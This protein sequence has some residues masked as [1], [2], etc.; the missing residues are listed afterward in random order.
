MTVNRESDLDIVVLGKHDEE[1]IKKI[2]QRQII[3]IN[4]H[5]VSYNEF[6]KMLNS[7]NP[8][9]LEIIKNHVLFGDISRIVDIFWRR[10][11]E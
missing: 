7:G 10:E 1:Q 3:E 6:A 4:E 9:S 8:L 2:K 11:M 5:Y